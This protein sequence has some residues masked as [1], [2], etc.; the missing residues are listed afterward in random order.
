VG[1]ALNVAAASETPVGPAS[2]PSILSIDALSDPQALPDFRGLSAR[3]VVR[4][5]TRIGMTAKL[6]GEGFVVDQHPAPGSPIEPG[7]TC[8]V[9]LARR[10]IL[11]AAQQ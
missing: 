3:D 6:R 11:P 1:G 5:L 8:E 2:M 10:M 7:A 9:R 4:T